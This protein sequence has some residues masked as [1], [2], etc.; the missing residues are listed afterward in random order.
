LTVEGDRVNAAMGDRVRFPAKLRD[1]NGFGNPGGFD[2]SRYMAAKGTWT[3][4]FLESPRLLFPVRRAGDGWSFS[5]FLGRLRQ[6]AADFIDGGVG[7]PTAGLLKAL[8]VGQQGEL[9]DELVEAFRRLGLSHL[10]AISGLHVGLV[11]AAG[12]FL[13]KFLLLLR[14]SNAL[15]F[16]VRRAAALLSLGPVIFYAA[17]AGGRPST[18]RAAIMAAVFILALLVQRRKDY[19]TALAAAAWAVLIPSPGAIFDP[20][21]QLSFAAVGAII[22]ALP[23]FREFVN[24]RRTPD[25]DPAPPSRFRKWFWGLVFVSAAAM[26][27]TSPIAAWHFNRLPLLSL[28]ANLVFTPLI[29]V[30]VVPAGLVALGAAPVWPGL[31]EAILGGIE[32]FLFLVLLGLE[33]LAGLDGIDLLVP[34]PGPVFMIGYY[35]VLGCF[36]LVQPLRKALA[37]GALA[38]A[39]WAVALVAPALWPAGPPVLE[40]TV[41]D[42]GQ[43]SATHVSLPDG[44][45]LLVDGG[46][47]PGGEFDPGENLIAP[48]LLSKGVRRMDLIAL[49]HPQMDHAGGLPFIAARFRPA[50]FWSNHAPSWNADTRELER[51]AREK[52]LRL[53]SLADLAVPRKFG[54]AEIEVLA[55]APDYLETRGVRADSSRLNNESLVVKITLGHVSFLLPGDLETEGIAELLRRQHD[56]LKA[57]VLLAPHHGSGRSMTPEFLRAVDPEVVIFSVGRQNRFGF[58]APEVLKMVEAAGARVYRTDRDGAVTVATE[59]ARLRV[60]TYR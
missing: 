33:A 59:G 18:S 11:A 46:G 55:P 20:S 9:E 47:F 14:P 44:A 29:A 4:A 41:L 10:L 54:P 37:V 56:R 31:G 28:P 34:R 25:L 24:F 8:T 39:A 35:A 32:Y 36:F 16:D 30:G 51:I 1:V 7:Q 15:R 6:R 48:Y 21:F 12:F 52:N 40:V 17:L 49:T 13:F 43:G 5:S 60:E 2:Y 42:V 27:G 26:I 53:P 58:P 50:E 38:A 57:D 19:L 23:R 3:R 22:L 45:Q